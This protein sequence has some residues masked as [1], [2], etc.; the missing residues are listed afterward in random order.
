MFLYA[1]ELMPTASP[2]K[3]GLMPQS[4]SKFFRW[5]KPN[6]TTTNVAKYVS[7]KASGKYSFLLANIRNTSNASIYLIG[8]DVNNKYSIMKIAGKDDAFYLSDKC[9]IVYNYATWSEYAI[10]PLTG[11]VDEVKVLDSL[12]QNSTELAI[13]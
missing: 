12:P 13:L 1:A 4:V 6:I 3:K 8:I 7:I 2:D 11:D 10:I 9:L 5:L